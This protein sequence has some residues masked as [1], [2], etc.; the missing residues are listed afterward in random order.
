M[1]TNSSLHYTIIKGVIQ[2]GY[3]PDVKALSASLE[4]DEKQLI[5][6]L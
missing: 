3:A 2:N 4:T 1:I 6:G 5:E